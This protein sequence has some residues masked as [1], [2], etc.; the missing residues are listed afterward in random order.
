MEDYPEEL[1]TPPV[2]LVALVGLPEFHS[3]ISL[4]LHTEQ[5]PINTLALPDFSNVTAIG[6]KERKAIDAR[7]PPPVGILKADWLLKHRTRVPAV[8]AVLF[9][10][11][12]VY[13]DPAQWL[14]V[15]THLD[16]IKNVIRGRNI[17]LV[18]VIVQPTLHGDMNEDRL[19]AFRKRAEVDSR[20]C[21]TFISHDPTELKRSLSRLGSVLGELST[22]FYREEGR[23][24]KLRIDKRSYSSLDLSVRY[25]FKV[26]V[27]AEFRRDWVAALKF[28]ETA[29]TQLQ[30]VVTTPIQLLPLQRIIELK[31]VAE[32]IHFKV[33]T[34]L[35]H[36]GKESEAVKWFKQHIA[37]YKHLIGPPDGAFMHWAWISRQ[38][39]VFAELLQ[40]SFGSGPPTLVS[41]TTLSGL[42]VTDR[43]LQ[44][45]YYYQVAAVYMARRRYS[46]ESALT[47]FEAFEDAE[48]ADMLD[49][50]AEE[51]GPPLYIGQAP[52]LLSP[53]PA[54]Y[55]RHAVVMEKNYS[56]SRAAINLL[57]KA[58]EQ[59]KLI[60]AS[61]TI[62]QLGSEMARE[63][64]NA[65]DYANAKHLFDTVA[66]MYRKESWVA[67]LGACLGY[68]RECARQLGLLKEFVEYTLE[69]AALP[70]RTDSNE[71]QL[72]TFTVLVGPAG[73]LGQFQRVQVQKEIMDVLQ[74]KQ[75]V[76]PAREGDVGLALSE[77]H[78]LL[79]E[80][81]LLSPLRAV[82]SV[83]VAFHEQ[84]IKPGEKT[85]CTIALLTH[86]PLPLMI[87]KLEIL[88]NQPEC[89]VVLWNDS[90][91]DR[92]VDSFQERQDG[93]LKDKIGY[94]LELQPYKWKRFTIDLIA[95]Q[96]GRLECLTATAHIGPHA[97]ICCQ[98]ESPATRESIPLWIFEPGFDLLPFMDIDLAFLGQK[99]TQVEEP[100]AL[101]DVTINTSSAGLVGELFSVPI[102]LK[103]RGH[104][105]NQGEL[106]VYIS[107]YS[108][109]GS[110]EAQPSS[111]IDPVVAAPAELLILGNPRSDSL[112]Q[113]ALDG[114]ANILQKVTGPIKIASV[115][116][117][118][119][120]SI[121]LYVRWFEAQSITLVV[122]LSYAAED[123]M[124]R[125]D[126]APHRFWLQRN[127][128]L[129]CEEP[130][131]VSHHFT[132]PY[133]RDLLLPDSLSNEKTSSSSKAV[134]LP[135]NE[136]SMLVVTA[137]NICSTS[138]SLLSV[139]I[140]EKDKSACQ[141]NIAKQASLQA[142]VHIQAGLLNEMSS[143]RESVEL[144]S[145]TSKGSSVS[146]ELLPGETFTQ[147]FWVHPAIISNSLDLGVICCTWKRKQ[148]QETKV[149]EEVDI[150]GMKSLSL[151]KEGDGCCLDFPWSVTSRV[152]M[153][154]VSVEETP[155]VLM[156]DCPPY[157]LLGVPFLLF[158]RIHNRTRALQ[159]VKFSV[160]DAQG[161][162]FSG[163]SRD[164]ISVLP[165][166][167]HIVSLKLVP[168][169]SGIQQLPQITL[170]ASRFSASFQPSPSS[171]QI[172]VFPS[173]R[174]L[175]IQKPRFF[176]S[177]GIIE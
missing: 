36:S 83:C 46:F 44:P 32:Q 4:F 168:L 28:Y 124:E 130:L 103:S 65:R 68:L 129:E 75:N 107:T 99:V 9:D 127:I 116:V 97:T 92:L 95:G 21:L 49:G 90:N 93:V 55:L 125:K 2:T 18:M 71:T 11:E 77:S 151:L 152:Q 39:H 105:I 33:A 73:P 98:V 64:F 122:S 40:T 57:T 38:F 104:A 139:E 19:V 14:Q 175:E 37:Y 160:L 31:G 81:D 154:A 58:H 51:I 156:L 101:I 167:T 111:P 59:Y 63:Y 61:R 13:G 54:E 110:L 86:M 94:N 121:P 158:F 43:E 153:S 177:S 79:L 53:T 171:T 132:A 41:N 80:V 76:L 62:Y 91:V 78:P 117:D 114:D 164:L 7:M 106:E 120:C 85:Q 96:S 89:N 10:R 69:L 30:E 1:R 50:P 87:T 128:Q 155:L 45:G 135:S 108:A 131:R 88:F 118:Q 134:V 145:K 100:E 47:T 174:A 126:L 150:I 161:F 16:N 162:L 148:E 136:R 23:R 20:N 84:T 147:L 169:A 27:Y 12:Q 70:V 34:L 165:L 42:T 149:S 166:S 15:C 159:E 137:K 157:A 144:P 25:N 24:V 56:H 60:Q 123:S 133:R 3:A 109:S 102:S 82:L 176:D 115:P 26:A 141:I 8:L 48:A 72:S 140:E 6:G 143:E 5:P 163:A 22:N 170:S 74:E 138:I 142:K 17:K 52:R 172:F 112:S 173:S 29:Y 146:I 67:L 66:G 113:T 119:G 35:L